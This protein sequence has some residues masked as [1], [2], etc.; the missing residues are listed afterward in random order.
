MHP[1][2]SFRDH[3]C[4][5]WLPFKC[6]AP[7]TSPDA[8]TCQASD[9]SNMDREVVVCASVLMGGWLP[10][11]QQRSAADVAHLKR[12]R[13]AWEAYSLQQPFE[14]IALGSNVTVLSL[15]CF[16]TLLVLGELAF[17]TFALFRPRRTLLL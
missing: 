11:R 14:L 2:L 7:S 8:K 17:N 3:V 1:S 5:M 9:P 6:A 15:R 16:C 13:R 4:A 12:F 10:C